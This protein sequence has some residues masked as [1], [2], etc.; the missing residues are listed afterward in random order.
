MNKMK[1]QNIY[2]IVFFG[3]IY[4]FPTC[5]VTA[6]DHSQPNVILVITDDQGYGDLSYYGNRTLQTPNLDILA[7][8]S[9]RLDNFHVDP[10]CSPTRAA[11]MTGRYS[12]RT[13]VW[14]TVMGRSFL[15]DNEITMADYFKNNGYRTGIIGKWH[16]G[17]NAPYRPQDRGFDDVFIHG[18][19]GIGQTP[20]FWGN[21]YFDDTYLDNGVHQS[22]SGYCTDVFFKKAD[23]FITKNKDRPFFLY[24]STNAPHSPYYVDKKYAQPFKQNNIPS[25]LSEF[26]GMIVNI[27]ENIGK[28][29]TRLRELELEQN[30]IFIFM[31]DNG[32][33]AGS[34]KPHGFN[35]GMRGAKGSQYEGGHRVPCFWYWPNGQLN[36][37]R[38]INELTAHIDLL[39]T[40]IDLCDLKTSPSNQLPFDGMSY[41]SILKNKN[42]NK[43]PF[44][45]RTLFVQSHR[46]EN[47]KPWRNSSVL[48]GDWRL[49]NGKELYH[50]KN[51]PSQKKNVA[52]KH[53]EVV[54]QLR[55]SYQN[56]Y[57]D[58]SSRFNEHCRIPLGTKNENPTLLTAHDWHTEISQIPWN[59]KKITADLPGQG[60]WAVQI[61]KSGKY[62][63]TLTQRPPGII[64]PLKGT[65]VELTIGNQ[66][67]TTPLNKE[68]TE[69]KFELEVS[70]GDYFLSASL[71]HADGSRQGVYYIQVERLKLK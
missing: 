51:D 71:K 33:A 69:Q 64:H 56:W 13:G 47:P 48:K 7:A 40:L 57:E 58:V 14:H 65:S 38:S 26:Y 49:I 12:C 29:R 15:R 55:N 45:N 35:A 22:Q 31:T 63:F 44:S 5:S 67:V 16:L 3:L 46:I 41:A 32:T 6:S 23:Q 9:A 62:R 24:L 17:D 53:A 39:P 59:Q 66:T 19:G 27:D 18:G 54:N 4:F 52:K 43:N 1:L 37:S 21:D 25:P 70:E 10:T 20:D 8:E 50:L 2:T 36:Q 42:A 28:L 61:I 30:T 68:Q 60:K 34:R 11:L